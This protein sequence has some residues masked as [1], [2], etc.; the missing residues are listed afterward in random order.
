MIPLSPVG[1]EGCRA[2]PYSQTDSLVAESRLERVT[3]GNIFFKG[4]SST[5][6]IG[7]ALGLEHC[8]LWILYLCS[9]HSPNR[10]EI[11]SLSQSSCNFWVP[12]RVQSCMPSLSC[13]K[14][15]SVLKIEAGFEHQA[16]R[17]A[18]QHCFERHFLPSHRSPALWVGT[19]KQA[20]HK[21]NRE[22]EPE[23]LIQ[24]LGK[25]IGDLDSHF[26]QDMQVERKTQLEHTLCKSYFTVSSHI[27]VGVKCILHA[28]QMMELHWKPKKELAV[29]SSQPSALPTW[30]WTSSVP[31]SQMHRSWYKQPTRNGA[32]LLR[33][34]W[35]TW[36]Q[37]AK[38]PQEG[39][40]EA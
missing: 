38:P 10:S 19:R 17:V 22:K 14:P 29:C 25:G 35:R 12:I 27:K 26:R 34:G 23:S 30:G 32:N 24:I 37:E 7:S 16:G 20:E 28:A 11:S 36:T 8:P 2:Y 5:R 1:R 18:G 40:V 15:S 21:S 6:G 33:W 39:E 13:H 9:C 4:E 3:R 31:D